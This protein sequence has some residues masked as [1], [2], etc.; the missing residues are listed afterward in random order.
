MDFYAV[1]K[2]IKELRKNIGISQ[3]ELAEGICTQ[4]Q[5]SKIEKGIVFPY[6]S[7]LYLIS[8]KLG[9]DVNYFFDIGMTPRLDYVQEVSHQLKKA[10]RT[11]NYNDIKQIVKAEEQ[12]PLFIQNNANLQIL[13]WHKGIYEYELDKD[14]KK[15]ITTLQEAINLTHKNNKVY[16]ER[17]LE[18]LISVGMF[19]FNEDIMKAKE[20]F[21]EIR[22]GIMLLPYLSDYT[23]KTRFFYNYARLLTRS[24][25][26]EE[27]IKYCQDGIS[28]CLE[29]DTM[30]LLGELHY[31]IGYN[32]ELLND[33][34][35]AK[36]YMEKAL[37][38]FEL[39]QDDKYIQ[40]IKNKITELTSL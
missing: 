16:S 29:K 28:W 9:V 34:D 27:S 14:V 12:N 2:K 23:I 15:A 17:E 4:A 13:K 10:R 8:Q 26:I 19:Y 6:A 20:V 30:F 18:I 39:Q 36:V 32:F 1:G 24:E 22:E 11:F 21:T 40:F 35:K 31:Q 5:I 33:K 38:V 7:T 37:V 3:E 25:K